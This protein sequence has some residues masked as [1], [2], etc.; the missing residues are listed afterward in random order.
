MED[1]LH[2]LTGRIVIPSDPLYREAR[3]DYNRAIQQYPQ[4]IDYCQDKW[5]V[6][7][8]VRWSRIHQVPLRIR[9]GGHNYEG[10]SNGNCTLIIDVSEMTCMEIDERKDQ[11]YVQGGVTNKL[12]YEF[13]SS[14]GYPFPGGTC[15]TVG[16]SGYALGGGWG[17][18][19]RYLGLG[20]DSLEEIEIVNYNGEVLKANRHC[21][22]DLFWAC[23]GAGGGNFGV[24]VSMAFALP[25]KICRVT[26]IEIDY[27]HVTPEEQEEF[28]LT[29]QRWL[30][31]ADPRVTLIS[32]IYNSV[33]D[34]FAML[35]RGI[36][37]GGA[38]EAEQIVM[39]FLEL[40]RA[41]SR[42]ETMTFLEAVTIIGSN[43]P[44]F[45][46]FQSVSR[47]VLKD[48]D[49]CAISRLVRLIRF[50]AEGSVFAG[51]SMYALG[52]KV[53]QVG[54]D[55][56]AFFYRNA[57]FII[58][59]ET[60]W[61]ENQY[62]EENQNWILRRF[63]I[64]ASLTKGSYVNFPYNQ[65]PDYLEEYYGAHAS[66]LKKIK[67]KYDPLNIFTFPQGIR[68]RPPLPAP[69]VEEDSIDS[70]G[71]IRSDDAA[72]RGFRYVRHPA[73]SG[74]S[75]PSDDGNQQVWS[76]ISAPTLHPMRVTINFNRGGTASGLLFVAPYT[77]YEATMIGQTGSLIMDQKGN[78]IWFKPLPSIYLQNA[79]FR[80]QC[81]QGR[82]VLTM[83][84]GT[85]SGTQTDNPNL[86]DG[87]PEPGAYYL[88]LNQH[89]QVIKKLEAQVGY[90]S[91]LH[92][93]TLTNRN[94]ALFTAVKQIPA[95][96]SPYGGPANGYFDDYSIQEVDLETGDLVFFWN[97]I[98]HVDPADSMLPAESALASNKIWDCFHMNSVEEGPNNTL[99][100][101]MR[102][103]WALYLIDKA[104]GQIIWQLG[105]DKSNFSIAPDAGFSWQHDARFRDNDQISLFDDACCACPSCPSQGPAR[106]L[107]LQLDFLK[108]TAS[109]HRTYYHDP[110][111]VVPSQGNLQ[112]LYNGN[113][114][115]GWGQE[116]YLSEFAYDGNTQDN[117]SLNFLYDM[118]YP[119]QNFTYR[120]FKNNWIGLPV[121]SPS[122]VIQ[123]TLNQVTIY[124]SWNGTT[125]TVAWRVLAGSSPEKL[126]MAVSCAIRT[127]FET[128]ITVGS[129][130]PY[131]QVEALNECG[132]VIGISCIGHI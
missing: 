117:L 131:F 23:R 109:V 98:Q 29:W 118:Q 64:L 59:L 85:I 75:Q 7:N 73:Q 25:P 36:F 48:F 58:W 86:P 37:Y 96:L 88:I 54:T 132:E 72:Y 28:L 79:E 52:G 92:E 122:V 55:Q 22:A 108:W 74:T 91:D 119:N 129:E 50:R 39:P 82:P 103:M 60:V 115:V 47:F 130:G 43:Y 89:Y 26:L 56:T 20:C 38:N 49:Q 6:A 34:G 67:E 116:P 44:D 53:R 70:T 62:K 1:C 12:V 87:D 93:F 57:N 105:G 126:K 41:E 110:T 68:K 120:A 113:P 97:A 14:K 3:L 51:L 101:S 112:T 33:N 10:Y 69:S 77:L 94:T 17:L 15:P 5:D 80:V 125:E 21:N 2:G 102:N 65:L 104:S 16:V 27:L 124:V 81:Y 40:P 111:L 9:N 107:I 30:S 95:D 84:E 114:F 45:E 90:T 127:G 83:W 35:V 71:I 76:F 19:C 100:I 31:T 78:P 42:I 46:K 24:I 18:S 63:P 99:L 13:V 11:L 66:E 4:I 128:A 8:A 123:A 121:D 32:R 106:G 61:E